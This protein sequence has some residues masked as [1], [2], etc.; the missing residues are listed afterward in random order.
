[1]IKPWSYTEEYKNLR[2]KILNSIDKTLN[3]GELFFGNQRYL[4]W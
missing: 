2:K 3:S 4:L 1:M